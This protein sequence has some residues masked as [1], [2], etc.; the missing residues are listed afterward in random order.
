MVAQLLQN[1][2][3]YFCSKPISLIA[4]GLFFRFGR[5]AQMTYD[6]VWLEMIKKLYGQEYVDRLL[7]KKED[8]KEEDE[9]YN[10]DHE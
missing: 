3:D 7:R 9:Q 4:G 5:E 10:P 6:N 1:R 8:D 2:H